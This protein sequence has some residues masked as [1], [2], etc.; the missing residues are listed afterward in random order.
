MR[1]VEALTVLMRRFMTAGTTL[2]ESDR[3]I[4]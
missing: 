4:G 2:I 3:M 1:D